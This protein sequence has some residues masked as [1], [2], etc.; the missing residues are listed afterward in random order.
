MVAA[1]F[2]VFDTLCSPVAR[3]T[4][5]LKVPLGAG[6]YNQTGLL[7]EDASLVVRRRR[8]RLQM[9]TNTWWS[10]MISTLLNVSFKC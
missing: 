8:L 6:T 5:A 3:L 10:E 1:A 2:V 4:G 9:E 7:L